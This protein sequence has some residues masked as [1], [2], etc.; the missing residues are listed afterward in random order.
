MG[1]EW[2]IVKLGDLLELL[3]DYHANGSYKILKQNIILLD[4]PDY[5]IMIR[6][7]NF[8]RNEFDT[9]LKYIT[10]DAEHVIELLSLGINVLEV[11][12]ETSVE[13][14]CLVTVA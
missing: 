7:T 12:K 4:E 2:K 9:S 3:T 1:S 10:E 8:E 14:S 13:S 11:S 5:A 6:T